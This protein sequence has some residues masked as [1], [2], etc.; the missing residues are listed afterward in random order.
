NRR[1]RLFRLEQRSHLALGLDVAGYAAGGRLDAGFPPRGGR[2]G[3][4]LVGLV[5][6]RIARRSRCAVFAPRRAVARAIE[7]VARIAHLAGFAPGAAAVVDAAARLVLVELE[8]LEL[9]LSL[10][11]LL[12]VTDQARVAARNEGDRQARLAGTPGAAD[13]VHVVL[14]VEWHVEVEHRGHV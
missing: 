3:R 1:R 7:H 4:G 12:D 13:A 5:E 10:E 9:D 8:G 2:G 6:E 14:G 11:Q